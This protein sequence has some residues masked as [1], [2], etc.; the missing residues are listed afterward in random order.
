MPLC[1]AHMIRRHLADA[2][3]MGTAGVLS[4]VPAGLPGGVD[5]SI[6]TAPEALR[7]KFEL[8]LP[9]DEFCVRADAVATCG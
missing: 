5:S 3:D 8:I 9:L 4:R 1:P 6:G 2:T 7:G